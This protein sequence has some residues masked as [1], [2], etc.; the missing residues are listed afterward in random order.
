MRLRHTRHEDRDRRVVLGQAALESPRADLRALHAPPRDHHPA[1][2]RL[3]HHRLHLAIARL[4]RRGESTGRGPRLEH[5]EPQ[6][7]LASG[8][9][10][11]PRLVVVGIDPAARRIQNAAGAGGHGREGGEAQALRIDGQSTRAD[12][13]QR[14]RLPGRERIDL[15]GQRGQQ[16]RARPRQPRPLAE[17][18]QV[19]GEFQARA[20]D[21]AARD[22]HVDVP[23][24]AAQA[25]VGRSDEGPG[26]PEVAGADPA[27]LLGEGLDVALCQAAAEVPHQHPVPVPQGR[28]RVG[29][30]EVDVGDRRRRAD[31]PQPRGTGC[32][33]QLA[34]GRLREPHAVEAERGDA[35][36][37]LAVVVEAAGKERQ[38]VDLEHAPGQAGRRIDRRCLDVDRLHQW[39]AQAAADHARDRHV[40]DA[41]LIPAGHGVEIEHEVGDDRVGG[42]AAGAV[43]AV[44]RRQAAGEGRG[45]PVDLHLFPAVGVAGG[46]A[47][48]D[49]RHRPPCLP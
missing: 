14:R 21:G 37:R 31:H 10:P 43:L 22:E 15:G 35:R 4:R 30:A 8:G 42:A 41:D 26:G 7:H 3:H 23:R 20:Q 34:A 19:V 27:G 48:Q 17:P 18:G 2:G 24:H 45:Q 13:R 39:I 28:H 25:G 38:A 46:R 33:E 44:H 9:G 32:G 36:Q 5:R 12:A 6:V 11:Q 1:A 49:Q 47:G 29:V 16:R 40:V